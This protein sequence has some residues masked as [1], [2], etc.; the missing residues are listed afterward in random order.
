MTGLPTATDE[1][2]HSKLTRAD[3]APAVLPDGDRLKIP[4]TNAIFPR[5]SIPFSI[6]TS[7]MPDDI[8]ADLGNGKGELAI[9]PYGAGLK[10]YQEN[11]TANKDV[12]KFLHS[13]VF[14]T[15]GIDVALPMAKSTGGK[16]DREF[17]GPWP[18]ILTGASAALTEFLL[19]NQTFAINTKL[20]FL[21]H[22][23]D[24]T[25]VSWHMMTISG[26]AVRD[27]PTAKAK[28]LGAIKGRVWNDEG[29]AN[30]A[31][32]TLG[33]AGVPGS[34]RQRVVEATKSF[35]P[36][37]VGKPISDDP[38]TQ[39]TWVDL[40]R[41]LRGGYRVGYHALQ[42]DKQWIDCTGCK[43][44]MHPAHGCPLP[45]VEGWLGVKPD[46]AQRHAA[47]LQKQKE[48]DAAFGKGR[49]GGRGGSRVEVVEVVD[50]PGEVGPPLGT[51]AA[52]SGTRY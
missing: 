31:D 29:L 11:A 4:F 38:K 43:S 8:V 13:L 51:I 6:L 40:I 19:W 35:D 30:F 21:A 34:K 23:F 47:R 12:E 46:N 50:T 22:P 9:V 49:G 45:K 2:P 20:T 24:R 10:F 17:G 44:Q 15:T 36:R 1:N 42:I 18:M 27:T 37:L 41:K 14:D 39:R 5:I 26:D 33:A 28:V 25:I 48:D 16:N 7:N 52:T 3:P 32:R